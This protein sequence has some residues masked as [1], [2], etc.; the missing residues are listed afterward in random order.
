MTGIQFIERNGRREYAVVPMPL[1]TRMAALLEGLVDYPVYTRKAHTDLAY[2]ACVR[3]LLAA[4]DAIF[5]QFATHNAHTVAAVLKAGGRFRPGDYEFQCLHGM[6]E[7][8]YDKAKTADDGFRVPGEVV[9][10]ILNGAHPV[11]A[12]REHGDLTQ[13]ALAAKAGIST[14]YLCQIETGKRQGA[15]KTLKALAKALGVS[16]DDLQG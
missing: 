7:A 8:L 5:P 10:A 1:F 4:P 6:G 14:A 3:R 15:V 12:W 11:K 2:L 9:N 16:L 13:D